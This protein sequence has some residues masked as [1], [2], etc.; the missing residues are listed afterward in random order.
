M[1]TH[2]EARKEN[3]LMM[4]N[5]I[6]LTKEKYSFAPKVWER[7]KQ[8]YLKIDDYIS[9]QEKKDELLKLYRECNEEGYFWL[10][11][12]QRIKALEEA[13]K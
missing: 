13:L 9:Q 12:Q 6:Q 11:I 3:N 4:D 5:H 10:E 2:E 7:R 8:H 1:I